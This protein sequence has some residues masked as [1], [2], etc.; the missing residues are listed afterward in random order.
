MFATALCDN[1]VSGGSQLTKEGC[2]QNLAIQDLMQST[3]EK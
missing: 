2:G 1:G 3:N